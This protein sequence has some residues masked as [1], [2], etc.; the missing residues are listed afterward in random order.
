[1]NVLKKDLESKLLRYGKTLADI[2]YVAYKCVDEHDYTSKDYCCSVDEFFSAAHL[3]T[4][5]YDLL[6]MCWVWYVGDDW[7][8]DYDHQGVLHI[9]T[10]PSKPLEHRAPSQNDIMSVDAW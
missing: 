6:Y 2:S 5:P 9:H 4:S 3:A 10:M 8:L 7:W 1:M